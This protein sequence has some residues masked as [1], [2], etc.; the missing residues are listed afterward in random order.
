M[1]V[2]CQL[3]E[4]KCTP[5]E[6]IGKSLEDFE[7][8]EYLTALEGWGIDRAGQH[9]L[10]WERRFKTFR[11]AMAFVNL[12]ADLAESEGHH[13]DIHVSWAR[14]KLELSTNALKGLTMND[15]VMAAKISRL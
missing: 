5:C 13:P 10:T 11:Q 3:S 1:T 6:G 4:G 2:I 15:F 14:V 12:V 7:E 9:R 8:D